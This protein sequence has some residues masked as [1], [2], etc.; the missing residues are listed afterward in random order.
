MMLPPIFQILRAAPNV[1]ALVGTNPARIYRH[2]AAPQATAAPYITWSVITGT[3]QNTL[4]ELPKIDACVVQ[5][6]CWSDNTGTGA[7]QIEDL[8]VAVRAALEPFAHMTGFGPNGRDFE[9]QRYR[10]MLQFDYWLDRPA[11]DGSSSSSG[12]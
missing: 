6:D 3:P 7:A 10:I 8:A 4:S 5:I 1:T 9:T 11:P 2:G 12:P